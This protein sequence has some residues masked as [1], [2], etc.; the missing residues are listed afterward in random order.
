MCA[1]LFKRF[2][3]HGSYRKQKVNIFIP[4]YGEQMAEKEY[5]SLKI[6]KSLTKEIESKVIGKQGF[7]SVTEFIKSAIR[8]KLKDFE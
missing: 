2:L 1:T 4:I 6:P 7:T 8:E 5:T 3:I